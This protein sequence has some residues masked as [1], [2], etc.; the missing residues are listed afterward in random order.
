M[1]KTPV[2]LKTEISWRNGQLYNRNTLIRLKGIG[3]YFCWER[4]LSDAYLHKLFKYLRS[5]DFNMIR[6]F[7]IST[8][9]KARLEHLGVPTWQIFTKNKSG[10]YNLN[11][12]N[13]EWL[14]Y[15]KHFCDLANWH[16]IIVM[17]VLSDICGFKVYSNTDQYGWPTHPF[18]HENNVNGKYQYDGAAFFKYYHVDREDK[19]PGLK[20][21]WEKIT[22]ETVNAL[23]ECGNV[24][25]EIGNELDQ[26]PAHEPYGWLQNFMA[27]I[28]MWTISQMTKSKYQ[29]VFTSSD[30]HAYFWG[31]GSNRVQIQWDHGHLRQSE[32][33]GVSTDGYRSKQC[34]SLDGFR[35]KLK[36]HWRQGK[37]VEMHMAFL[38]DQVGSPE[39]VTALTWFN[40]KLVDP[41]V[42]WEHY[43]GSWFDV[44][45]NL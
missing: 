39:D 5:Y 11:N 23:C 3:L 45:R 20:A 34:G 32:F 6:V 18:N 15:I 13:K 27:H 35:T 14:S 41:R 25:F 12:I 8:F 1:P 36:K 42:Q 29:P 4:K 26:E 31:D 22:R 43:F 38:S 10:K 21:L 17:P 2:P 40:N 24:I 28:H 19:Y 30:A 33:N 16:G 44:I 9:Q 7:V 37:Y